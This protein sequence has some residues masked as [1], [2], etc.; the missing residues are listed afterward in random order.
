MLNSPISEIKNV[1]PINVELLS[2]IDNQNLTEEEMR[3]LMC[4]RLML[5]QIVKYK[6]IIQEKYLAQISPEIEEAYSKFLAETPE[7]ILAET[8]SEI[9]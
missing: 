3:H 2:S 4:K 7:I 1:F 5:R 8:S 6:Y 9:L